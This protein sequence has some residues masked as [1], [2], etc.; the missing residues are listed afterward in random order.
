[1]I[2]YLDLRYVA[3][4]AL[5]VSCAEPEVERPAN[6]Q[7]AQ[8]LEDST[9]ACSP[10]DACVVVE[11][12]CGCANGGEKLAVPLS[13]VEVIEESTFTVFCN[14]ATNL[15]TTCDAVNAACVG[16]RCE[17]VYPE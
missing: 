7:L 9:F 17:L 14:H 13:N 11:S 8:S 15:S 12:H 3:V 6:G 2:R 10:D 5:L 16:G 4:L 1:V